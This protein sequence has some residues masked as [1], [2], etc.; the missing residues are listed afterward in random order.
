MGNNQA[1]P[2]DYEYEDDRVIEEAA[3][4]RFIC[5]CK[6]CNFH[7]RTTNDGTCVAPSSLRDLGLRKGEPQ[8]VILR[9]EAVA[10]RR[11]FDE[12]DAKE[13]LLYSVGRR[14]VAPLETSALA[15][16]RL[17]L[18]ARAKAFVELKPTVRTELERLVDDA[19]EAQDDLGLSDAEMNQAIDRRIFV[20]GSYS[21]KRVYVA[22]VL[23]VR[24]DLPQS[25]AMVFDTII[26][27]ETQT[28]LGILL[29]PYCPVAGLGLWYLLDSTRENHVWL[30][31]QRGYLRVYESAWRGSRRV[32][33]ARRQ[34]GGDDDDDDDE[35]DD[36]PWNYGRF[37]R[38]HASTREL[39]SDLPMA[40]HDEYSAH[41]AADLLGA[42]PRDDYHLMHHTDT[43]FIEIRAMVE[44]V[45]SLANSQPVN[46]WGNGGGV[47][48]SS[49]TSARICPDEGTMLPVFDVR[50][51]FPPSCIREAE[52]HGDAPQP[53]SPTTLR[54]RD[55]PK[56]LNKGVLAAHEQLVNIG[57]HKHA[58]VDRLRRE[59]LRTVH[60]Q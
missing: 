55:G 29:E 35:D 15:E 20:G 54:R 8:P 33:P 14:E 22:A 1:S 56:Q 21:V 59:R 13:Q 30:Q 38:V 3:C 10:W 46:V 60:A 4:G 43:P 49:R 34:N 7:W 24:H 53:V 52:M 37:T 44:Y 11:Q 6:K 19:D 9:A 23:R 12:L 40:D 28:V 51:R 42:R 18:S 17:H 36:A 27:G 50:F 58:L 2:D 5:N 32:G 41:R 57:Q 47:G 26:F 39:T 25:G 31:A 45:P 16:A 48:F